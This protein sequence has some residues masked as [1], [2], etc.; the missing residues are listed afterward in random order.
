M[1][2]GGGEWLFI[3]RELG[4]SGKYFQDQEFREQAYSFGD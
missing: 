3:F 2:R 4:S 1:G